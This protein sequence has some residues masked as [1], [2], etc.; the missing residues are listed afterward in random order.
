MAGVSHTTPVAFTA[1]IVTAN[2]VERLAAAQAEARIALA[3][4]GL[5][6][7]AK[8]LVW[9]RGNPNAS[10]FFIGEAP[11]RQEDESGLPFV[12]PSGHLLDYELVM[13]SFINPENGMYISNV[14]KLW[15]GSGNPNPTFEQ[16]TT[17]GPWLCRQIEIVQPSVLVPLGWWAST[18]VLTHFGEDAKPRNADGL[19][20]AMEAVGRM[21][22]LNGKARNMRWHDRDYTVIPVFHPAASLH[23]IEG[24]KA[25]VRAMATVGRAV[26]ALKELKS[27]TPSIERFFV[28]ASASASP[29]ANANAPKASVEDDVDATV[30]EKW[31]AARARMRRTPKHGSR[32]R[33]K[34]KPSH[35]HRNASKRQTKLAFERAPSPLYRRWK[36]VVASRSAALEPAL[37]YTAEELFPALTHKRESASPS[38]DCLLCDDI[39]AS[40]SG[41]L[42][43]ES[44]L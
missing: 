20:A 36:D 33:K 34:K 16:V 6:I 19:K 28:Q 15:P 8:N 23:A 13:T 18:F 39:A 22:R 14:L 12:G 17:H 41:S 11:G 38:H 4:D 5:W 29:S 40:V 26:S 3:D 35:S 2:K 21:N 37:L 43:D 27:I 32:H 31:H 44:I 25:F 7:H 24:R 1:P 30:L 10:V 9:A 42:S